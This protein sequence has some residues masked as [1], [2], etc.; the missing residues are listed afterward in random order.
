M[1][2]AIDNSLDT[3]IVL[4]YFLGVDDAL[5][6]QEYERPAF[7][8]L[9]DCVHVFLKERQV[10]GPLLEGLAVVIGAGRFT[11]TR[12]ATTTANMLSLA[13]QIPVAGIERPADLVSATFS[14]GAYILPTYSGA[15]RIGQV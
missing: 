15:A 12:V 14:K 8:S 9:L 6:K 4:Y 3:K 11:L 10:T 1:Y 7:K 13:W 5:K 2:I